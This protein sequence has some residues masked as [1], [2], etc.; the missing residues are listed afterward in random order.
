MDGKAWGSGEP[1]QEDGM[2]EAAMQ[3]LVS[4]PL[5]V[6]PTLQCGVYPPQRGLC[7][8]TPV[9]PAPRALTVRVAPDELTHPLPWL[10]GPFKLYLQP[11]LLS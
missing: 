8:V 1:G 10:W 7:R 11:T 6:G 9:K 3:K 4:Q 2:E 5:K